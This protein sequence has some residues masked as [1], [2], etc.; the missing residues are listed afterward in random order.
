MM[1]AIAATVPRV[2]LGTLVACTGYRNPGVLVKIVDTMDEISGGRVILG[3]GGGDSGYEH[4]D[5]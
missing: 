5:T 3:V 2:E 4:E 1:A